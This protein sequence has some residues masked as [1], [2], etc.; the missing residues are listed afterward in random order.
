MESGSESSVSEIPFDDEIQDA[1]EPVARCPPTI[2]YFGGV[3]YLEFVAPEGQDLVAVPDFVEERL[4]F[5]WESPKKQL[6][7]FQ[8][9]SF[10]AL[11]AA[12][13]ERRDPSQKGSGPILS[14]VVEAAFKQGPP[15][16]VRIRLYLMA[17]HVAAAYPIPLETWR[18]ALRGR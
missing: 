5:L 15:T 13:E 10:R 3:D 14:D 11:A 7:G 9:S 8:L 6:L 17:K 1:L 12:F 18:D 2:L 4:S 16:D